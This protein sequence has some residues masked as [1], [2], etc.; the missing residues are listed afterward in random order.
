MTVLPNEV[1]TQLV[2]YCNITSYYYVRSLLHNK[3]IMHYSTSVLLCSETLTQ[4][5][6]AMLGISA[7]RP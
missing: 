4:S 3:S 7:K 2:H 5:G 1:Y 6:N